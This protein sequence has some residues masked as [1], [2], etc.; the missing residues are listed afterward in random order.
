MEI[1]KPEF[2]V[3]LDDISYPHIELLIGF[4]WDVGSS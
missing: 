1:P 3:I 2:E 4:V